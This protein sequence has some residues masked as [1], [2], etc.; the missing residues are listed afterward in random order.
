MQ[1]RWKNIGKI[2]QKYLMG[3]TCK[4]DIHICR[5][6]ANKCCVTEFHILVQ[7]WGFEEYKPFTLQY[8]FLN[9][10]SGYK[11]RLVPESAL[12]HWTEQFPFTGNWTQIIQPIDI[13][14][15]AFYSTNPLGLSDEETYFKLSVILSLAYIS[16]VAV[17]ELRSYSSVCHLGGTSSIPDNSI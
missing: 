6:S 10:I 17:L 8:N 11:D 14:L 5:N 4:A 16:V 12:K 7:Y 15:E 3:I 1:K 13:N 9:F 2:L